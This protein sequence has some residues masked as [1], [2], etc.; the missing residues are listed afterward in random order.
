MATATPA[1]VT[2]F[3]IDPSLFKG[4]DA[5]V[6]VDCDAKGAYGRTR[7]V[8]NGAGEGLPV[9]HVIT[10]VDDEGLFQLIDQRLRL[11]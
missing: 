2:A 9:C 6:E 10:E 1:C 8:E 4:V 3:L 7:A 11:L 5:A